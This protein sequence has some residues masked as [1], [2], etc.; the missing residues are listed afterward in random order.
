MARGRFLSESVAK[1]IRLNSMSVEAELVYLMTIPHLDRDGLIEGDT[2]ILYGTVCPKRRQFIDRMGEFVQEWVHVGLVVYYETS[3]GP[4]L[5]FRGFAKNQLGLRYERET[6]SRFPPPPGYERGK[7]GLTAIKTPP[8]SDTNGG[9]NQPS[10]DGI[11]QESDSLRQNDGD[12]RK[13]SAQVQVQVEVKDQYIRA[14]DERKTEPTLSQRVFDRLESEWSTVNPGQMDRH[15]AL[16]EK[17]GYEAWVAG[18]ER[19]T[20]GKRSNSDYVEK[21]ILSAIDEKPSLKKKE[22]KAAPTLR[23]TTIDPVTG[24]RKEV[25]Q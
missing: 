10:V 8:P 24:V 9:N 20:H 22:P 15:S 1:D 17:Y 2:E 19:C 6:E 25:L 13:L 16:A 12:S 11:R 3:E 14:N 18:L 21:A 5:W 23:Y 4:I 7:D